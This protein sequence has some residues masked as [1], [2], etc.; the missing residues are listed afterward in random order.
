M[1]DELQ[2]GNTQVASAAPTQTTV[3]PAA[4]QANTTPQLAAS[5]TG[6]SQQVAQA[7]GSS[8]LSPALSE[9]VSKSLNLSPS[10]FSSD[11]QVA[12]YITG[13][14]SS[15]GKTINELRQRQEAERYYAQQQAEQARLAQQQQV[16]QPQRAD[17]PPDY[18]PE[19]EKLVT[20]NSETGTYQ[21]IN[22][23]VPLDI[24]T[25]VNNYA[26]Y[27]RKT[28]Q[29]F[30]RNPQEFIAKAYENK[31]NEFAEN[32]E[33]SIFEK[34]SNYQRQTQIQD[35]AKVIAQNHVDWA[36][37]KD[38]NGN[39]LTDPYNNQP[40]MTQQGQAYQRALIQL[41]QSG[42]S[43]PATLDY[44]ALAAAGVGRE[45]QPQQPDPNA[46]RQQ[47]G[48]NG[49][50]N[51][52]AHTAGVGGGGVQ[53]PASDNFVTPN[54]NSFMALAAEQARKQGI[55]FSAPSF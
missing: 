46:R 43:D 35:Q 11:Q 5:Q 19:W 45:N 36:F 42:M 39:F 8:G 12:E 6:V 21:P 48:S 34:F 53:Q 1:S 54:P 44:F 10:Q 15:A 41:R 22:S 16:Q 13:Q 2:V 49:N 20:Y 50:P 47:F 23:Y 51:L 52:A 9:I 3:S 24:A 31:L 55:E 4:Q 28:Q 32:L 38:A 14:L 18:D 37:Q 25:K 7:Q 29:E 33:K 26:A 40:I 17:G 27:V 30:L